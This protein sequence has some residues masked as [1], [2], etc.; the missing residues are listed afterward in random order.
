MPTP[1]CVRRCRWPSEPA[2]RWRN[3]TCSGHSD[4]S[5]R[6]AAS[7]VRRSKSISARAA[8]RIAPGICRLASAAAAARRSYLLGLSRF[9]EAL[10]L[11]QEAFEISRQAPHQ[12]F[13]P[14]RSST[15]RR[16]TAT[17]GT[18]SARRHL[19]PWPSMPT[20]RPA[21]ARR[22]AG[23]QAERRH[24]VRA[25]R[26][27]PRRRRRRKAVELL[28]Q[29]G[30]QQFVPETMA[31]LALSEARRG[32]LDAARDW[33]AARA[34]K[35]PTA[36]VRAT[37]LSTTTSASWRSSSAT[38]TQAHAD[39]TRVRRSPAKSATSSTS[40][41]A[42]V[43][44]RPDADGRA[45]LAR[46]DRI[47][48]T[49][50]RDRRA[51]APDHSRSRHAR[52][53]HDQPRRPVRDA[54]RGDDG[55]L[56]ARQTTRRCARRC[57]WRSARAAAR[58]PICW[59]R[60][61]RGPPIRACRPCASQEIAF[62]RRFSSAGRPSRAAA[63]DAA[64]T[65]AL[66]ELRSLEHEYEALVLK[67]RRENAG[68]AALAY[69][70]ALGADGDL[71]D[72]RA[73]RGADRV[74]RDREARDSPGSCGATRSSDTRCRAR[75]RS[76]R[77]CASCRR[78]SPRTTQPALERLGAQLYDRLIGP[79]E[80]ALQGVRRLIIVPDGALQRVPF[81]LL[82]PATTGL[83]ERYIL[84]LAPSATVLDHLRQSP[85]RPRR[86]GRCWRL[87]A[88]DAAPGQAALFDMAPGAISAR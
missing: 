17:S 33:S 75:T 62:G 60:P 74:P 42:D 34:R 41:R 53:V 19:W 13:A 59:R 10:A 55:Q 21:A 63:D 61:G 46:G 2:T 88:P 23:D 28:R 68:Y 39:F 43:G 70:R 80:P 1:G 71:A 32:R 82:R 11:A 65:A 6:R 44:A 69:P 27:R 81:A 67:I 76:R 40:W 50:H 72:A 37:C 29:G 83:I 16:R 47:A 56:A 77:R 7:I 5:A 36:P 57:T 49:G 45:R 85:D 87:A 35:S 86:P 15:S 14:K 64:R 4:G 84:A 51:A 22:G 78:S 58:S 20:V 3:R 31:R 26:L 12:R 79:A 54:R 30:F 25:R 38:S 66:A 24:V 73:R 18:S 8:P 52:D 48:R 9:D